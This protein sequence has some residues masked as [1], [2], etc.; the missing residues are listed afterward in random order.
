MLGRG[1]A[2]YT[3]PANVGNRRVT[4]DTDFAGFDDAPEQLPVELTVNAVGPIDSAGERLAAFLGHLA[5]REDLDEIDLVAHSMG[6]LFSRAAIRVLRAAASSPRIGSL[7][8]LGTPWSGSF[9]ADFANGH[10]PLAIAGGDVATE[11]ILRDYKVL[12]DTASTGAGEQVTHAY[13]DGADGWNERQG[14]VLEGIPV[15]LIAGDHFRLDGGHRDVFPHDGLVAVPSALA[16]D[17]STTVLRPRATHLFPDV[18]SIFFADQF[19][20]PWDRALTWNPDVVEAVV[21]ALTDAP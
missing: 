18:H 20:L 16:A 4:N 17:V 8:T 15:T 10:Q 1:Y 21:E 5:G 6:G 2:V 13:L 14:D 9:A 19:G 7:V 3:S 11:T 12:H